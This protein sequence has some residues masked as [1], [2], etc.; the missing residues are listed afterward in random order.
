M[1]YGEFVAEM[2]SRSGIEREDEAALVVTAVLKTLGELMPGEERRRFA[3][4]LPSEF[5]SSLPAEKD[6]STFNLEEFY[7]RV[8]SRSDAGYRKA[9]EYAGVVADLLQKSV[10][11]GELHK[12]VQKL[13]EDVPQLFA[14]S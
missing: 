14:G 8:A 9:V 10:S 13:P 6:Q 3:T 1:Q 7:Q 4:Q 11:S 5:E 2:K 12:V